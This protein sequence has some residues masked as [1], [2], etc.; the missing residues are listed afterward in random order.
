MTVAPTGS[1]ALIVA[2]FDLMAVRAVT[3]A[4]DANRIGENRPGVQ[5]VLR[6]DDRVEIGPRHRVEPTPHFEPRRVH[7]PEPDFEPRP[8]ERSDPPADSV[9]ARP[10]R[11]ALPA[12]WQAGFIESPWR[13]V[14]PA[15]PVAAYQP[16]P[17]VGGTIDGF[18]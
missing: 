13:F 7:R 3:S 1:A 8:V 12:P 10:A 2:A 14:A 9:E 16:P 5:P 11:P 6:G 15:A 17:R 18:L 4:V